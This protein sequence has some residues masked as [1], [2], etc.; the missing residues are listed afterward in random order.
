M[1]N[2][3]IMIG[4]IKAERTFA[5]KAFC[6]SLNSARRIR[7]TSSVPDISPASHIDT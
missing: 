7:I 4:Y 3:S 2:P 6:D 5:P 1:V